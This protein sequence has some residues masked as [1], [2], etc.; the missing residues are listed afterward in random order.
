MR[1]RED[2]SQGINTDT[3]VLGPPSGRPQDLPPA[4]RLTQ[5]CARGICDLPGPPSGSP[6]PVE[7]TSRCSV[8][9]PSALQVMKLRHRDGRL[10]VE[11]VAA[12]GDRACR[13][14]QGGR[15]I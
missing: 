11:G 7:A 14:P 12:D 9:A 3:A 10:V 1:G 5:K 15:A 6:T 4:P 13:R 2:W 8:P